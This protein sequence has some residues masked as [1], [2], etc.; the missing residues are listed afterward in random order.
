MCLHLNALFRTIKTFTSLTS[1]YTTWG[2][3]TFVP[4]T[5]GRG[6]GVV[7]ASS[8]QTLFQRTVAQTL[9]TDVDTFVCY[10]GSK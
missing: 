2:S 3:F 9:N 5:P 10:R 8:V 1:H 4:P 7:C 6:F